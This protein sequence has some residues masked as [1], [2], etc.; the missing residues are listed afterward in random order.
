MEHWV[1]IVLYAVLEGRTAT[2]DIAR[3]PATS[4]AFS[5]CFKVSIRVS[6]D[7]FLLLKCLCISYEEYLYLWSNV[8]CFLECSYCLIWTEG[9]KLWIVMYSC[10]EMCRFLMYAVLFL[11]LAT[12]G[13]IL[14]FLALILFVSEII[15]VKKHIF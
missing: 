10:G 2:R 11:S 3:A 1:N 12:Y 7:H 15:I 13:Q 5:V 14:L 8:Y 9:V 4:W 6:F